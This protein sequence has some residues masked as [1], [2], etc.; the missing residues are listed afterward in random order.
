MMANEVVQVPLQAAE[1]VQRV[2]GASDDGNPKRRLWI[3]HG[4]CA[5][6]AR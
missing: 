5:P 3:N 2:H 6:A 4:A 1:T